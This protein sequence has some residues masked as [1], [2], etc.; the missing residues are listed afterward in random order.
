MSQIWARGYKREKE[1]TW[2]LPSWRLQSSKEER[3]ETRTYN[4]VKC[5][6]IEGIGE[7]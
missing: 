6:Q 3:H 5:Y 7:S 4:N 2:Y 1:K